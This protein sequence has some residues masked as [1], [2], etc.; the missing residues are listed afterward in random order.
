[1]DASVIHHDNHCLLWTRN[2]YVL[3]QRLIKSRSPT[4]L[5]PSRALK[6][7]CLCAA[8]ANL[9]WPRRKSTLTPGVARDHSHC[10]RLKTRSRIRYIQS[11]RC[12]ID[13]AKSQRITTAVHR[14]TDLG[15]VSADRLG[16]EW[17][18]RG[19]HNEGDR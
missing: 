2:D 7:W 5:H 8:H 13:D 15:A 1:L 14:A 9:S 17:R 16:A 18:C 4:I 19:D 12:E 6:R 3:S 11:V 10:S